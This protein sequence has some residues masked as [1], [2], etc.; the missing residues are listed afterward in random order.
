MKRIEQNATLSDS[1][2]DLNTLAGELWKDD[3][4][5]QAEPWL[6]SFY[7][8]LYLMPVNEAS[9]LLHQ[10][11]K[12][13]LVT[14]KDG[15]WGKGDAKMANELSNALGLYLDMHD[16]VHEGPGQPLCQQR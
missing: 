8:L 14:K 9:A 2:L 3:P 15:G 4:G 12:W 7:I 11:N 10:I 1:G 5:N 13:Q 16:A 6:H